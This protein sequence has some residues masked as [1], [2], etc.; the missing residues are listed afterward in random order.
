M[1]IKEKPGVATLLISRF[2]KEEYQSCLGRAK[3]TLGHTSLSSER[4]HPSSTSPIQFSLELLLFDMHPGLEDRYKIRI[5]NPICPRACLYL[6]AAPQAT[7]NHRELCLQDEW[8]L[9]VRRGYP[10]GLNESTEEN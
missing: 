4:H 10:C 1:R 7:L 8:T 5:Y 9:I 3:L 2:A 6:G